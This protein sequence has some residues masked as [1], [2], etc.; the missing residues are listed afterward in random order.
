MDGQ[1]CV[2]YVE[3]LPEDKKY[4]MYQGH[5]WERKLTGDHKISPATVRQQKELRAELEIAR[6]LTPV[7][8]A[9]ADD[10]DVDKLNDYIQ[11]SEPGNE[12]GNA[13]G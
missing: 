6:E 8:R 3:K 13:Q 4:V 12:G 11:R 7:E 5:A 10:L 9:S 1:V 2:V